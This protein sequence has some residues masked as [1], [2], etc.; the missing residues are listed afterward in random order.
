MLCVWGHNIT[1]PLHS[2]WILTAASSFRPILYRDGTGVLPLLLSL[3][4]KI[5]LYL[6]LFLQTCSS[7]YRGKPVDSKDKTWKQLEHSMSGLLYVRFMLWPPNPPTTRVH[8]RSRSS[9]WGGRWFVCLHVKTQQWSQAS[10]QWTTQVFNPS[11]QHCS[12]QVCSTQ[13]FHGQLS[14]KDQPLGE[15]LEGVRPQPCGALWTSTTETSHVGQAAAAAEGDV[16]HN[17]G[18]LLP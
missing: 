12:T 15:G 4:M 14:P 17:G 18:C 10:V 1:A 2:P 9:K 6:N 8:T 16:W 7:L 13:V 3:S 11:V 5:H